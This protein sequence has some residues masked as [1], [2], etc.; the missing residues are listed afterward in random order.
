MLKTKALPITGNKADVISTLEDKANRDICLLHFAGHGGCDTKKTDF[1]RIYLEDG[2]LEVFEVR[3]KETQLGR[4]RHTLVFLN[5]CQVARSGLNMCVIGG[6]AEALMQCDFGGL[7]A[8]LWAV[9]DDTAADVSKSFVKEVMLSYR[10]FAEVLSEIRKTYGAECP[11]FLSYL[12]Y[13]DVMA[14]FA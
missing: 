12:Y 4:H 8:P 2:D 10:P 9:Y 7:I 3:R 11:T 13:G 6:F 1:A 5:A 14:K